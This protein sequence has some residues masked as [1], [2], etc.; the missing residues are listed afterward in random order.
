L[1]VIKN[2]P[3]I[4]NPGPSWGYWIIAFC[5][6]YLPACVFRLGLNIG[7]FIAV[8]IMHKQR[9]ASAAYWIALTGRKPSLFEQFRHF[10]AFTEGLVLK[11]KASRNKLPSFV[12]AADANEVSFIELCSSSKQVLF[13]TFHVGYSDMMGCML[14]DFDRQISMVRLQVGNSLDL[15]K[16]ASTFA[17]Q[18]KFLWINDPQDLIFCLKDAMQR[19][20]SIGLQCDRLGFGSKTEYF[21]F[22][23]KRCEFPMTIYHLAH[24][25]QCPVVFSYTG[26]LQSTGVIEGYT[27]PTFTPCEFKQAN[28]EAAMQH[29]QTVLDVLQTHLQKHPDLWFNF[30]PL[31]RGLPDSNA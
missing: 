27:S 26:P 3:T 30:I 29:F 6:K 31:N 15:E 5:E 1:E 24:M 9:R 18:V 13:G 7:I 14:S 20:E 17:G 19:G 28:L 21:E 25:F 23:G 11:L 16:M 2:T 10:A 22:L 4:S 12:F 8:L